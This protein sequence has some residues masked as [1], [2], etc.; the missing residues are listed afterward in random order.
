MAYRRKVFDNYLFDENII[1][2][3]DE[4]DLQVRLHASGMKCMTFPDLLIRHQHR[5]NFLSFTKMRWKYAQGH[6][7]L[8]EEKYK[9]S[10]FHWDDLINIGFF[11]S[12]FYALLLY[13]IT[14]LLFIFPIALFM[15]IALHE[16]RSI[17]TLGTWMVQIYST[18]LWTLAKMYYSFRYHIRRWGYDS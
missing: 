17:Y 16:K 13:R 15:L 14:L 3:A 5:S 4:A 9:Q 8:Y 10:L 18:I 11:A 6:T 2:G 12:L 1:F 7:Y